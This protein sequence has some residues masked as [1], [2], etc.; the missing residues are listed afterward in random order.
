MYA[1]NFDWVSQSANKIKRQSKYGLIGLTKKIQKLKMWTNSSAGNS[2]HRH[3]S[4]KD[5]T[6][7]HLHYPA[8]KSGDH[9]SGSGGMNGNRSSDGNKNRFGEVGRYRVVEQVNPVK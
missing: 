7:E 2:D 9:P 5:R 4:E 3:R 6:Y 1:P 8:Q